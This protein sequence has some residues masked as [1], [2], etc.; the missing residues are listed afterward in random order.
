M[1]MGGTGGK[2][3]RVVLMQVSV[4]CMVLESDGVKLIR[5][6]FSL[7]FLLPGLLNSVLSVLPN[8]SVHTGK[9]FSPA[10]PRLRSIV[11][12]LLLS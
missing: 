4:N 5:F 3:H 1:C 2:N 11:T 12:Q 9:T 6:F 7:G 10:S 8:I